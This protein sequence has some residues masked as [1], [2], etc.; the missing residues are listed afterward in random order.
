MEIKITI[1]DK[2]AEV[3]LAFLKTVDYIKIEAIS[4]NSNM[5]VEEPAVQYKKNAQKTECQ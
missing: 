5:L 2:Y 4:D 1:K 3:F